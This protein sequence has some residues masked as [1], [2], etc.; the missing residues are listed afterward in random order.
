MESNHSFEDT[1]FKSVPRVK[2]SSAS[3]EFK[4]YFELI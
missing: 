2:D 3:L 1:R 4:E